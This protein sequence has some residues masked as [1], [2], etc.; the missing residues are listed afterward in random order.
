MG[1]YATSPTGRR[2]K[3]GTCENLYYVTRD[4]IA[5]LARNGWHGDGGNRDLHTYLDKPFRSRIG[6]FSDMPGDPDTI[7]AREPWDFR[8]GYRIPATDGIMWA[9]LN[10]V[11][12]GSIYHECNGRRLHLPCPCGADWNSNGGQQGVWF[13][14]VVAIGHDPARL[15]FQ[16]PGCE[17]PFNL[18]GHEA[19]GDVLDYL[20]RAKPMNGVPDRQLEQLIG[21]AKA[22]MPVTA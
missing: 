3:L 8:S 22:G 10:D 2:I 19:M 11:E 16:C 4:D 14:S 9:L 18:H 13:V 1:E 20:E 6:G 7:E 12:H 5:V 21:L 15:I 17:W